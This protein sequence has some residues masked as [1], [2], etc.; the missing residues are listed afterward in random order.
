MIYLL[1]LGLI[2]YLAYTFNF[3]IKFNVAETHFDRKRKTLHN[4]LIWVIPFLWI[5]LLKTIMKP[6]PRYNYFKNKRNKTSGH[7]YESG[8]GFW[9]DSSHGTGH[10]HG[11]DSGG[12]SGG[13]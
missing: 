2:F 1:I 7:F 5:A 12:D 8:I 6:L 9:G 10:D 11:G 13:N 4:I 3:A